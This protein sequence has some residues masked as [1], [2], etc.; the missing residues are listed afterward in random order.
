[1]IYDRR[2]MFM[3]KMAANNVHK[4]P[5]EQKDFLD[6]LP[7]RTAIMVKSAIKSMEIRLG[8]GKEL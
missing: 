3:T 2:V 5:E 4:T 1:M 8:K 7:E 6:S